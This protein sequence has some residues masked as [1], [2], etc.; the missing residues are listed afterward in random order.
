[1]AV[2][3]LKFNQE[4]GS[5]LDR[6]AT[7]AVQF[8]RNRNPNLRL[9]VDYE[10]PSIRHLQGMLDDGGVG[11]SIELALTLP[12][13]SAPWELCSNDTPAKQVDELTQSLSRPTAN[14]GMSTPM[15][16]IIAQ[17][18]SAYTFRRSYMEKV[19]DYVDGRYAYKKV[20]YRPASDCS[21]VQDKNTG[22]IVGFEQQT[23]DSPEPVFIEKPYA[24]VYVHG[25]HRE[26]VRGVCELRVAYDCYLSQKKVEFLWFLYLENYSMP[27]TVV[28][29]KTNDGAREGPG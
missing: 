9:Y 19:V 13:T 6:Y 14:G 1:V 27:R 8:G 29:G 22:D 18:T 3:A 11:R 21:P 16:L 5:S 23:V 15:D 10:Y 7:G 4:R 25:A 26:P 17:L 24:L 28:W 12:V 20:A 2:V